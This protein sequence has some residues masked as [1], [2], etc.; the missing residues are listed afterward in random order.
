VVI[1]RLQVAIRLDAMRAAGRSP[2]YNGAGARLPI[3]VRDG[4]CFVVR[5]VIVTV[6]FLDIRFWWLV[7]AGVASPARDNRYRFRIS[8]SER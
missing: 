2:P 4:K 3:L 7:P 6:Y 1:G 5:L 8:K